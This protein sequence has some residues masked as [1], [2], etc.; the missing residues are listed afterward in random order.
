MTEATF[1][2]SE[3]PGSDSAKISGVK[4]D[5]LRNAI[6]HTARRNYLDLLNRLL[7]FVVVI[8]GAGVVI[9]AMDAEHFSRPWLEIG[10]LLAATAQ[11]TFDFGAK[12]RAHEFLQKK[13]FE[14]ISEM[15]MEIEIDERKWY[16]KLYAVAA[17]EPMPMRALDA[18]AYNAALDA[19]TSD[20]KIRD[21][22]R[23]YIPFYQRRLR[24]IFAFHAHQ[25]ILERD[26]AWWRF[27]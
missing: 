8:L 5:A 15:E 25:Y 20:L 11:L 7:N 27:W 1:G 23:V 19:M 2:Q 9:K 21:K 14:M 24:H 18:M 16:A 12:A 10:V 26:A 3:T 22:N 17:E 13:Y 6:Y 4:F